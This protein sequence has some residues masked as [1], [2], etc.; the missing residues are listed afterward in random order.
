MKWFWKD[1]KKS[2]PELDAIKKLTEQNNQLQE[3]N[4][5]LA[6]Q[7]TKLSRV[8]YKTGKYIQTKIDD[9]CDMII[10]KEEEGYSDLQGQLMQVQAQ[11]EEIIYFLIQRLDELDLISAHSVDSEQQVWLDMV[12][13][14]TKQIL[15]QL[16]RL[17]VLELQVLHTSFDPT[18]AES[19]GTISLQDAKLKY[20]NA[21]LQVG[22]PYQI[23]EVSKRGFVLEKGNLLRKA[24]VITIEKENFNDEQ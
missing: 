5:Q 15:Q 16:A 3:Q 17:G 24:Q 10:K 23:V 13:Q 18:I 14:W 6:E 20:Q 21:K 22:M 4:I 2:S 19:I 1:N 8:Q 11:L 12:K 7:V 9:L